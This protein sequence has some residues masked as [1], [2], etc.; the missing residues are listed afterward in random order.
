MYLLTGTRSSKI[1]CGV[2]FFASTVKTSWSISAICIWRA[3]IVSAIQAFVKILKNRYSI[4][5][6]LISR[7]QPV[8]DLKIEFI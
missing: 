7:P 2:S 5:D 1:I 4:K 6:F 8:M 3:I